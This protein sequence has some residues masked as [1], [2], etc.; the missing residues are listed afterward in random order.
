MSLNHPILEQ[1]Y[2]EIEKNDETYRLL[3][4]KP[5]IAPVK[6]G[7]FPLINDEQLVDIAKKADRSLRSVDVLTFYD[8][9][10]TIGRRYA[11][12]DEIGT[13]FC[14]T[15]DHDTID[16]MSVT[17]RQRDTK[18]QKRIAISDLPSYILEELE[19]G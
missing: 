1:S 5:K 6:V 8:D 10:G 15:V 4:L 9:G 14:V 12:M 2:N 3:T 7:V 16:D 18:Q 19:K 17:V 11:R 13:P